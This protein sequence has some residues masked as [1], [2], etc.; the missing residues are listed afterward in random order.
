MDKNFILQHL[1]GMWGALLNGDD[2]EKEISSFLYFAYSKLQT[3]WLNIQ[4]QT[5]YPQYT[6]KDE[7][8]YYLS[9]IAD[10]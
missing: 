4:K 2:Q 7:I 1:Y 8:E 5:F 9:H 6:E 10:F 3:K